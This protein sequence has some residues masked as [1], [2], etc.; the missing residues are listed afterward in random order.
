MFVEFAVQITEN[1]YSIGHLIDIIFHTEELLTGGPPLFYH[2]E[3]C[4]KYFVLN[5]P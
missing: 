5:R 3:F 2:N 4:C 1:W